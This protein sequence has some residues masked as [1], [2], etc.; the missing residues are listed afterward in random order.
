[1]PR[2]LPNPLDG[3][4]ATGGRLAHLHLARSVVRILEA[5]LSR[6]PAPHVLCQ[7]GWMARV[8]LRPPGSSCQSPGEGEGPWLAGDVAAGQCPRCVPPPRRGAHAGAGPGTW[9]WSPR[10][11]RGGLEEEPALS[12]RLCCWGFSG[13]IG[14]GLPPSPRPTS[15]R[16][17]GLG[18]QVPPC[19]LLLA[20]GP[21]LLP[22]TL[23]QSGRPGGGELVSTGGRVL[24]R[25]PQAPGGQGGAGGWGGGAGRLR[26]G[27][28]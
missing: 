16:P 26:G 23:P 1:M 25:L 11:P 4:P 2:P 12:T 19:S 6:R 5:S 14:A 10:L 17:G 8:R 7:D 20:W 18:I 9:P 15:H 22:G 3:G 27:G 13:N 28:S 24:A 21:W